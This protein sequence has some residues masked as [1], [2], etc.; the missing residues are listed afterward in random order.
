MERLLEVQT[1][2]D[3]AVERV[4]EL[5]QGDPGAVLA[6][7]GAARPTAR[8]FL[9]SLSAELTPGAGALH[10]VVL[11]LGPLTIGDDQV[12]WP[13]R[14]RPAAHRR[15]LPPFEGVLRATRSGDG[16]TLAL[17]GGYR[18]PLGVI[19]AF[20]DGVVGHR[21]ARSTAEALL[22]DIAGRVQR[23]IGAEAAT[24]AVRPAPYPP[25]LREAADVPADGAR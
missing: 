12:R 23:R 14:W 1:R 15:L 18:P 25:D 7:P 16:T 13:L 24:G 5:I 22:D 2:I 11:E 3:A 17:E 6:P 10:E 4:Q 20:G 19:G 8:S 9:V 21:L